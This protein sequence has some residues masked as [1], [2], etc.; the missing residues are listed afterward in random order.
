[1]LR[2]TGV[3]R[4]QRGRRGGRTGAG[5]GI[6]ALTLACLAG[7]A[8]GCGNAGGMAPPIDDDDSTGTFEDERDGSIYSWI[9]I[10]NQVW[11]AENL[12][13]ASPSGSWC[14][15]DMP[16]RCVEYGRLYNWDAAMT[17]CPAGWHL[18]GDTEW[19]T[20]VEEVG[21]EPGSKLKVGGSSGFEAKLAGFRNYD[22]WF[23]S[24]GAQGHYWTSTPEGADHARERILWS[25]RTDVAATGF[26][27]IAGVSVRC[28]R[29]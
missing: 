21:P 10:R 13:F 15:H 14:Y 27:T 16:G 23:V 6:T 25:D 24:L 22:G 18:P 5:Y 17:A 29:D 1:M 20:L 26:G 28:V 11:M 4:T 2:W 7:M 3:R 12:D 8:L 19:S 9:R